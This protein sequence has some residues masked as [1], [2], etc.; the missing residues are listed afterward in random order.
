MSHP[1]RF[2]E[3]PDD[4]EIGRDSVLKRHIHVGGGPPPSLEGRVACPG[5]A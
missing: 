4:V 2:A 1:D 3:V 5:I